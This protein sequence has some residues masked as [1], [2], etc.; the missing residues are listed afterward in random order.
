MIPQKLTLSNFMCYRQPTRLD[1]SDIHLACLT[2]DNGH[3]KS[4][5]LDAITWALWGK[6]RAR[7][8]DELV[9]TGESDM[10]VCLDFTLDNFLYRVLRTREL[11]GNRGRGI[12]ELQT[13]LDGGWVPLTGATMRDTQEQINTLLGMDHETFINSAFL[14]QGHADEFTIKPPGERKQVLAN[15]LGLEFYDRCAEAAKGRASEHQR[16]HERMCDVINALEGQLANRGQW[17]R[18]LEDA[19]EGAADIA[20]GIVSVEDKIS[21]LALAEKELIKRQ[22]TLEAM[23]AT[24]QD[25]EDQYNRVTQQLCGDRRRAEEA[26][27]VLGRVAEI[28]D[29]YAGLVAARAEA[30]TQGAMLMTLQ[31]LQS[32]V[33]ALDKAIAAKGHEYDLAHQAKVAEIRQRGASL[34][35]ELAKQTTRIDRLEG[36][37]AGICPVCEQPL[38]ADKKTELLEEALWLCNSLEIKINEVRVEYEE[39]RNGAQP[40][41]ED[42]APKEAAALAVVQAQI[43]ELGYDREKSRAADRRVAELG[44]YEAE[45]FKLEKAEAALAEI[46]LKIEEAEEHQTETA[47]R[48]ETA[49][50]QVADLQA[51]L[52][53]T[54]RHIVLPLAAAKVKLYDLRDKE[55]AITKTLG[56]LQERIDTLDQQQVALDQAEKKLGVAAVNQE[57]YGEL[58]L[59]FG[60]NGLQALLIDEALPELEA[61]TNDLLGRMTEGRMS[62]RF[63]TQ[64]DNKSGTVRE[65][66]DILIADEHGPRSYEMFSGGEAFRINFAIRI[67]LSKLLAHRAGTKLRTLIIDE[68]FGTQDAMGRTNLVAAINTVAEDFARILVITHI[69]ELQDAFPVRIDVVK[70]PGGSTITVQ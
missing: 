7:S 6:A 16:T 67:A 59:A 37:E 4:A 45:K 5:L 32:E 1:F 35:E 47:A 39:A 29:G 44:H 40:T 53:E 62:V 13:G 34:S 26:R 50:R 42:L 69:E 52:S 31:P 22:S 64:R 15:I 48:L 56:A 12:L 58:G 61:E 60:K 20:F 63:E 10:S 33:V 2:G 65:T 25:L 24:A 43:N 57:I 30:G 8:S 11:I 55:Q 68:G 21:K 38:D 14:V 17:E 54:G 49:K 9:S 41:D 46:L 3:G 70:G 18:D 51:E 19:Q 28:T 23:K 66:L 36:L 27:A